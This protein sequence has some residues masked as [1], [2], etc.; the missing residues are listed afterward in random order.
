MGNAIKK[1]NWWCLSFSISSAHLAFSLQLDWKFTHD[2]RFSDGV[3]TCRLL[4][5][6]D[7]AKPD[8]VEELMTL[9][10][11]L[12]M[13]SPAHLLLKLQDIFHVCSMLSSF[14]IMTKGAKYET[15]SG[16]ELD[17]EARNCSR[18]GWHKN[19]RMLTLQMHQ[20]WRYLDND[21]VQP[22]HYKNPQ[23]IQ[24]TPPTDSKYRS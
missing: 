2:C 14:T 8:A 3:S 15:L 21:C 4:R 22:M 19:C 18:Q 12:P 16:T 24:M 6:H 23:H 7:S 10:H 1:E 17:K 20:K 11:L 13:T 9:E 5:V